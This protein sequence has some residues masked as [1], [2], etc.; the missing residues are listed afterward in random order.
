MSNYY[1]YQKVGVM[2]A[3]KLMNIDGWK[4]YGYHADESDGMTDYYSPAYWTGVAEKNDYI[5]CFNVYCA[6][7]AEEIRQYDHKEKCMNH[8][9][10]KKIEKLKNMTLEKGA[11]EQE[12]ESARNMIEKL[13]SKQVITEDKYIVVGTIPKHL[14]NPLRCNWHIEKDGIIIAKGNGVLK[15]S[16]ISDYYNYETYIKDIEKFRTMTEENYK[17]DYI[18]DN[19][20]RWDETEERSIKAADYHYSEL[21]EKYKL[22]ESFESFVNKLDTTCGGLLGQGDGVIYEKV[23]VTEYKK[24]NRVVETEVGSIKDGQCFVLK[25]HFTYGKKKGLVYCIHEVGEEGK[26]YFKAYKM[27]IK[28]T[29]ECHGKADPTN[30]WFIGNTDNI[31]KWIGKNAISWCEIKEVS[32]SYEVEKIVKK[33]IKADKTNVANANDFNINN[34]TFT[35]T[36]DI[37]TRNNEKIYIVKVVEKLDR[38]EYIFVSKYI[39][40]LGGYYSK[41]KHGFL[42]KENPKDLLKNDGTITDTELPKVNDNEK[43]VNRINKAIESTQNKLNKLSGDYKTNTYKRMAEQSERERK[44]A[45]YKTELNLFNYFLVEIVNRDLTILEI[46]LITESFRTKLNSYYRQ[47]E[48]YGMERITYPQIDLKYANS[49]WNAEVPK[50]QKCLQ[51]ANITNTKELIQNVLEYGKILLKIDK[52]QDTTMLKIKK[53]E[54]EYKMWQKGDI[55]FTP[56]EVVAELIE[57]A[58]IKRNDIVLEPSAGIGNIADEIKKITNNIDVIEHLFDFQELLK[59]KGHTVVGDDFLEYSTDKMYDAIVMNP[60]FSDEQNHIKHAYSLLKCGSTLVSVTSPHWTF[61]N[62]KSSIDF[63]NWLDESGKTYYIKDLKR[64][65]FEMTNVAIKILVIGKEEK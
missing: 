50:I 13:Q 9:I 40:T 57:I 52:P 47:Y 14:A 8:N 63:R 2:I 17:K 22:I 64:G 19:I 33:V 39:K 28:L 41:F 62:D 34:L 65:I 3:H 5:L 4:V 21:K 18:Q 10:S 23:I 16:G 12:A 43:L 7:D 15:Y 59:L 29:K 38:E 46:A 26:K 44:I 30:T 37:D 45:N 54:R 48:K 58:N 55:N 31:S 11:C 61:A 49:Y 60:P 51:K 24:E 6:K 27:N 42:F 25:N 32:V 20:N 1:E 36:E 53:L 35:T 56:S